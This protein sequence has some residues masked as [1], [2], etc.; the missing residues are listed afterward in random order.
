MADYKKCLNTIMANKNCERIWLMLIMR[1][2]VWISYERLFS[3]DDGLNCPV[4]GNTGISW[5]TAT[6]WGVVEIMKLAIYDHTTHSIS[7]DER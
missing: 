5:N 2:I 7:M 1:L 3:W 4:T 6:C